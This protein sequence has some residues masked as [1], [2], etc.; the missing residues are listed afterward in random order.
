MSTLVDLPELNICIVIGEFNFLLWCFCTQAVHGHF[1]L[2]NLTLRKISAYWVIWIAITKAY[3][4]LSVT[5][6]NTFYGHLWAAETCHE[7]CLGLLQLNHPSST[8]TMLAESGKNLVRI[9]QNCKAASQIIKTMRYKTL[10]WE[11]SLAIF[12]IFVLSTKD[13]NQQFH[14][15]LP[16]LFK[17]TKCIV[18]HVPPL[19]KT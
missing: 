13:Q 14:L 2:L 9:N 4:K 19:P 8:T 5:C 6:L 18:W 7:N 1:N 15:W 11:V 3:I 16:L 12:H 17:T 10:S